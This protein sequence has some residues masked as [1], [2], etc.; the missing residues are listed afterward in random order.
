MADS[1]RRW[2]RILDFS[3]ILHDI[4]LHVFIGVQNIDVGLIEVIM[5]F[6]I[7]VLHVN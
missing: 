5:F 1:L 6:R 3:L 2:P 4:I 7:I